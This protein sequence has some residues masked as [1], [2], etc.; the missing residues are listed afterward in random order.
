MPEHAAAHM[1]AEH[2]LAGLVIV[3]AVGVAAQWLAWRLRWPSILLLL[4]CGF[5]AGPVTRFLDPD[6][7]FGGLLFPIVSLAVAIILFEGGLS[8]R[9]SELPHVGSVL[10]RLITVGALATWIIISLAAYF[11]IGF[12]LGLAIL[13]GAVLVVTGPTV[14]GPLLRHVRPSGRVGAVLKWEGIVIDPIGVMLAILVFEAVV[15]GDTLNAPAYIAMGVLRTLIIGSLV[16]IIATWLLVLV[17]RRYWIP[18][19]LQNS[20]V[21]AGVAGALVL[22]NHWQAESGLLAV[23]VMGVALANQKFVT[24]KHIIEFK[25]NLRVLLLP[26]LFIL[27]AA[28]LRWSDLQQ[29]GADSISFLIVLLFIARPVCVAVSTWRSGLSLHERG[30]LAWMAPRGIVATAVASIFAQRLQEENYPGAELLMP[31]TVVVVVGTVAIYGLTAAP[32]AR[33]LG[34]ARAHPRGVI[35]VGA[36]E[37]A[38]QLAGVLRDNNV[39]VLLVDTDYSNITRARLADLPVSHA[40]ILS[41]SVWEEIESS[42]MGRVFAV[43]PND[44]VNSLACMQFAEVF[45]R[46]EVYQ[47]APKIGGHDRHES[48]AP[49]QRGRLLIGPDITYGKIAALFEAGAIIKTTQLT[50]E[51]N[52]QDFQQQHPTALT[53]L[54]IDKNGGMQVFTSDNRPAPQAGHTLV[55]IMPQT[56]TTESIVTPQ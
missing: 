24:I 12:N 35:L 7:V 53:I 18:D 44:E 46:A 55:S 39:P 10:W 29:L 5:V 4:I 27:L 16:G 6:L 22:A 26:G 51:S 43:T 2:R 38:Q 8:L 56:S 48:V 49:H 37:W 3:L 52:Y 21:L 15:A 47:L 33:R 13:L 42:D 40:S 30:L 23:T 41:Q 36:H 17:L 50:T 25:E 31:I 19:F 34:V 54:L 32:L 11:V 28:R 45:G 1:T 14:I 20:M 9:L